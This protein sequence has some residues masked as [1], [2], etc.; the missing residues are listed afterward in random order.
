MIQ[1]THFYLWFEEKKNEEERE[2]RGER[3]REE[4]EERNTKK[5]KFW[6][7]NRVQPPDTNHL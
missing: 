5:T 1:E 7:Q 4:R 3:E 6:R 2:Q